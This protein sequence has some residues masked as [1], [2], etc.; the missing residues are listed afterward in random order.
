MKK[1]FYFIGV[2]F[3]FSMFACSSGSGTKSD[4]TNKLESEVIKDCDDFLNHYEEWGDKYIEVIDAYMKNPADEKIAAQYMDLMQET[5]N[6]SS[7]WSTLSQCADNKEYSERF[8][9]VA[10]EVEQKL[11]EIGL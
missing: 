3:V 7:K 5:L 2:L 10:K 6:W 4:E 11:R 9:E 8:E 1:I